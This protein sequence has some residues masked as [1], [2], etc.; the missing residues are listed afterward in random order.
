[1][2]DGSERP[3]RVESPA[4]GVRAG[5]SAIGAQPSHP[6]A[7]RGETAVH[8]TEPDLALGN[9]SDG[10]VSG[11]SCVGRHAS[12]NIKIG[13]LPRAPRNSQARSRISR[14]SR[15][16]T[17]ASN[18][19]ARYQQRQPSRPFFGVS[20]SPQ[21][22]YRACEAAAFSPVAQAVAN[23]SSDGDIGIDSRAVRG[24]T[25]HEPFSHTQLSVD[26]ITRFRLGQPSVRAE[27]IV[28]CGARAH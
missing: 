8:P 14:F 11:R 15:T 5:R 9:C 3:R 20:M 1:M 2:V 21:C 25:A 26:V 18:L 22:Q 13:L 24:T 17:D 23:R 6:D 4:S 10:G 16:V 7:W 27:N 28:T 19:P 12:E